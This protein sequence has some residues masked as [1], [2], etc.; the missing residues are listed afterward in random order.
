MKKQQKIV[1]KKKNY[2]YFFN[3]TAISLRTFET[4][5]Y[6][7]ASLGKLYAF[8]FFGGIFFQNDH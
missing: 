7:Y 2:M 8:W 5:I 1:Q 6:I 3:R 4:G